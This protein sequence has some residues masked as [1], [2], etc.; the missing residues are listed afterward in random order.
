[1][2]TPTTTIDAT[3]KALATAALA[4]AAWLGSGVE[5]AAQDPARATRDARFDQ[6]LDAQ[7][8]LDATFKDESGR[9]IA[10]G[11]LFGRSERPVVLTMVYYECPMLCTQV[12]N[13]FVKTLR[14]LGMEVG[15]DFD[16]V[17]VSIDPGETSGLAAAKKEA[18]IAGLEGGKV[19]EG[20]RWLVGPQSSIDALAD[21]VGFRY[22][23]DAEIDEYAHAGGIVVLTPEGR[24]SRYFFDVEFAMRDLRLALVEASA[25]KIGSLT[26]KVMLLCYHY[27]PKTGKYG[28]VVTN[29]VRGLGGLTVL[30]L[31]G[32]VILQ[33]RRDRQAAR[34]AA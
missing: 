7:V 27:D 4:A 33:L 19:A 8:P 12:L 34:V 3:R 11:E 24:V 25:G 9:D 32:F 13:G 15:E 2:K 31:V 22:W 6:R 16:I 14:V 29:V 18:Y 20:W 10:L 5:A 21:S 26:D 30:L 17:T 1:M 28:F 23:Y